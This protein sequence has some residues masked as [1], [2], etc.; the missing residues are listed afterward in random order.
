MG[1]I[2]HRM[3][4]T[5]PANLWQRMKTTKQDGTSNVWVTRP[6]GHLGSLADHTVAADGAVSPSLVCP[7][8][9]CTFHEHVTLDG[10]AHEPAVG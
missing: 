6:S 5:V 3:N 4:I 2:A 1:K 10:W 8:N 7:S 9:G